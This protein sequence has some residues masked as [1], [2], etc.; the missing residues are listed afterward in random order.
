MHIINTGIIIN[1][2][3]SLSGFSEF[4]VVKFPSIYNVSSFVWFNADE[5]EISSLD[6]MTRKA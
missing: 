5:E 2:K 6:G 1:L 3:Q 4:L